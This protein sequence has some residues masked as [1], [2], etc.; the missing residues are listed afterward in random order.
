MR[1]NENWDGVRP[2]SEARKMGKAQ[3]RKAVNDAFNRHF[4][5]VPVPLMTLVA[6]YKELEAAILAGGDAEKAMVA[7]RKKYSVAEDEQ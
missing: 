1:F 4:N 3:L 5:N 7:I 2:L 6:I